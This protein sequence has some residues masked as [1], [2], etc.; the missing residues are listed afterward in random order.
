MQQRLGMVTL[1][2]QDLPRSLRFYRDGLGWKPDDGEYEDIAF[3]SLGDVTLALYPR[4]KLAEDATVEPLGTGFS[5]IT[6]SYKAK[7]RVEVDAILKHVEQLGEQVVKPAQDVFWGGYSGYFAD[8][9][10]YLWEVAWSASWGS[11]TSDS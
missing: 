10:G 6:L 2:V 3:F 7:S 9:D 1:G 5:G 11:E 4:L 8:P